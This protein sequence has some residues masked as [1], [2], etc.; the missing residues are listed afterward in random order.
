[1]TDEGQTLDRIIIHPSQVVMLRHGEKEIVSNNV[2]DT[3]VALIGGMQGGD[4]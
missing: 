3:L 2:Q 4:V 1:M